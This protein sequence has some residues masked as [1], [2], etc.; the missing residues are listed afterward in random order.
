MFF[1]WVDP[2][3][4]RDARNARIGR[5]HLHPGDEVCDLGVGK[6]FTLRGHLQIRVGVTDCFDERTLVGVA[7]NDHG[8]AVAAGEEAVAGV[9]GQAA[10]DLL[11]FLAVTLVAMVGEDGA[12]F[13][14]EEVEL[15]AGWF[16]GVDW[17]GTQQGYQENVDPRDQ[18]PQT[19]SLRYSR[20]EICATTDM[21]A[22]WKGL[23]H[24]MTPFTTLPWTSVNRKSRPL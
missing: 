15:G 7:G 19:G 6:L 8:S 10:F 9:E 24:A 4:L 17:G 2:G 23:P 14:F 21:F 20:L 11:G 16:R 22:T 5:A 12:D 1:V 13:V 3:F 18:A